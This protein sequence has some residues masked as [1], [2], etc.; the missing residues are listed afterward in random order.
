MET[1]SPQRSQ[2][3]GASL[4]SS[5]RH[6]AE[7]DASWHENL[8]FGVSRT[9]ALT[10]PQLP[11]ELRETVTNAYLLCRIADTIEDDPL[12]DSAAK[13]MFHTAFLDAARSGRGA[14]DFVRTLSP[15]LAPVTLDAEVKLIQKSPE[16]LRV[17][18]TLKSRQRQAVLQCL[19]TMVRGMGE[20]ERNRGRDGLVNVAELHRYCYFVAGVVG[21]MLT[22]IFCDYSPEIEAVRDELA[23][24]AI[25][26]GL[27]LQMTNILKDIWDDHEHATCWLPREVFKRHGYDLRKLAPDHGED[28]QAFAASMHEL[29]GIAH[30]HLS[31]ALA[32]TLAIPRHETGIRRFLIWAVL[33]AVSTLGKVSN[34]PLFTSGT[35]VKVS[36]PRVAAIIAGSNT[37]IRSNGG[38]TSMFNTAA[39]GL[40]L[41]T[42]NGA[43]VQIRKESSRP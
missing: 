22:E 12:L 20:Y 16:V 15:R 14:D 17:T 31:E 32:Y 5:K 40:P 36:R 19:S 23:P 26:F 18:R 1:T 39:R 21:E 28:G 33:L 4:A 10:I 2:G 6:E 38:L 35:Q 37:L 42:E 25:S 29:V 7:R 9:F 24:R 11:N 41:N 8:L 30:Q 34:D 13:D 43:P 27:G 3:S